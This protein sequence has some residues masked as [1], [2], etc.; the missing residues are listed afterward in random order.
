[1]QIINNEIADIRFYV[2]PSGDVFPD[3]NRPMSTKGIYLAGERTP[4]ISWT[5]L[6]K[7][8]INFNSLKLK[9][10]YSRSFL[11]TVSLKTKIPR[12]ILKYLA[13][14][15]QLPWGCPLQKQ[16]EAIYGTAAEKLFRFF[17]GGPA[18][19]IGHCHPRVVEAI[20]TQSER[21]LHVMVMV[22]LPNNLLL[23]WQH[24]Y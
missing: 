3:K 22:S 21:Y 1:M 14:P 6:V 8:I 24:C 13:K 15:L 16:L 19:S 10:L 9:E 4:Q 17:A 23:I 18:C 20:K 5:C 2:S 12:S 7:Q 11:T